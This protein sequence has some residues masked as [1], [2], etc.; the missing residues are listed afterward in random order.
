LL[1]QK[2]PAWLAPI[3][4]PLARWM[5]APLPATLPTPV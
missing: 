1:A 2:A 4:V 3:L 5:P